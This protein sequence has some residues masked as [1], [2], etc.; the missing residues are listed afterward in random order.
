MRYA[1]LI[2]AIVLLA[3]C[4]GGSPPP[5]TDWI[6][7]EWEMYEC[8]DIATGERIAAEDLGV[9]GGCVFT[10]HNHWEAWRNGWPEGRIE[11]SGEWEFLSPDIYKLTSGDW[12]G[13]IQR[14]GEEWYS[15]GGF[16]GNVYI[17]W[18]KR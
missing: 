12:A 2:S 11:G 9:S 1:L 4:G 6:V 18:Y 17:F 8:E 13:A 3:G 5:A 7:G 10:Y 16:D 15:V 14:R